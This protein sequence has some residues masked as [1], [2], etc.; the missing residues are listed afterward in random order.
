MRDGYV[1]RYVGVYINMALS[2]YGIRLPAMRILALA[3]KCAPI[4]SSL[5][6][7]WLA[8][9]SQPHVSKNGQSRTRGTLVSHTIEHEVTFRVN[10]LGK[11]PQRVLAQLMQIS[12]QNIMNL[13][14]YIACNI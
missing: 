9:T 4:Y 2:S 6:R 13:C 14:K 1:G 5:L 3:S 7:C 8:D 10:T 12:D 11:S